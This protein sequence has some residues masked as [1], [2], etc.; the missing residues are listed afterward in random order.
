MRAHSVTEEIVHVLTHGLGFVLAVTALIWLVTQAARYGDAR[1]IVAVS[2]Y[3][4]ALVLTYGASTLY[5]AT[6]SPRWK[7]WFLQLD[8]SSIYL[9][10][11]GTYTPFSLVN[12]RGAWGW[13]LLGV[14]WGISLVGITLESVL[15]ERAQ[16][17]SLMLYLGQ[18]WLALIAVKP[19]VAS[20]P[21]TGLWL[22]L[23]GGLAYTAG[24]VFY[25]WHR[26]PYNHAIWHV[27]VIAG[28][29][30]HFVAVLWFVLPAASI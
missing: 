25:L 14:V 9:L 8:R 26:L 27:F 2:V 6:S 10:I 3:G 17:I 30:F 4:A 29:A 21:A 5:H 24:V 20:L 12:L 11:A 19:M 13:S 7:S 22:V 16:P 18:G 1:H 23:L 15:R 28:S